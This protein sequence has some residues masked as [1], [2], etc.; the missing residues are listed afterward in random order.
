MPHAK[1]ICAQTN[2]INDGLIKPNKK[3][4]TVKARLEIIRVVRLPI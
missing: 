1:R 4:A 2:K 3:Y